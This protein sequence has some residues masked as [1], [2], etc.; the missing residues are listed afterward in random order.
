M[1]PDIPP[2]EPDHSDQFGRP[3]ILHLSGDFPDP[4][5]PFKTKAMRSLVDLTA[6]RFEHHVISINRVSPSALETAGELL[7]PKPL[8]VAQQPFEYG[9]ALSYTAPL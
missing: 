9:T 3:L 6:T 4:I 5:E 2:A 7:F 1:A 8:K